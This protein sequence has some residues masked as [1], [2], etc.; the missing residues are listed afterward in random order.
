L[1]RVNHLHDQKVV[2]CFTALQHS[3]PKVTETEVSS[4]YKCQKREKNEI[5]RERER[6]YKKQTSSPLGGWG[7][8]Y[9]QA[10]T[11]T[12]QATIIHV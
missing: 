4:I 3:L 8:D 6:G 7:L 9:C 12:I 1:A 5:E 10:C 11:D 2:D